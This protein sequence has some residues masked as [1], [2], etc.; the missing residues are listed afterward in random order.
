MSELSAGLEP[1]EYFTREQ[2][3]KILSVKPQTLYAY[4]S[5][6]FIRSTP[7]PDGRAH[8]YSREDVEKMRAKSAARAGHG[9]VAASAMHWGEPVISTSITEITADGPRYRGR[10][11]VELARGGAH[12]EVVA[13]YLWSGSWFDELDHWDASGLPPQLAD[14]FASS[15]ALHA[16]PHVVP[17][18]ALIAR[19][20]GLSE[21]SRTERVRQGDST[22]TSA[23]RLILGMTG[24]FG[25]LTPSRRFVAPLHGLSVA[26]NLARALGAP[27]RVVPAIDRAL[28][29][30]ADH[31]LNPATFTARIAASAGSDVHACIAAALNVHFGHGIGGTSDAVEQLLGVDAN[32]VEVLA[33][34]RDMVRAQRK[35]PGFGHTLY[36]RGDRRATC[37]LDLAREYAV[38]DQRTRNLLDSVSVIAQEID[39]PPTIDVGLSVLARALQLPDQTAG[40]LFALG[41]AAGWTAH[42][43]EQRLA[44]FMIRPRARFVGGPGAD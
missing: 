7:R 32:P 42:I 35:I 21:G 1:T 6:G 30:V 40:A 26:A 29:L 3:L 22:I 23:R 16:D 5:R 25:I 19:W 41:R 20:L 4:V 24:G 17:M 31:E 37:L 34:T 13:E 11:A 27:D 9:A 14:L 18:L 2:A 10:D 8:L 44:G 39:S 36:P 12:Y 38:Q 15:S 33:R 43:V 28:V